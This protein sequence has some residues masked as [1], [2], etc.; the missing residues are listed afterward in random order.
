M[1]GALNAIWVLPDFPA[2]TKWLTTEEKEIAVERIR[3]D[4]VGLAPSAPGFK[5][6]WIGLKQVVKDKKIWLFGILQLAHM[7]ACGFTNFFPSIMKSIGSTSFQSLVLTSPPYVLATLVCLAVAYTSGR[8]NERTWHITV[9]FG[10]ALIGFVTLAI[11]PNPAGRYVS[12]FLVASGAYAINSII[13][14]WVVGTLGQTTEKKAMA[15]G[16]INIFGNS[17]YLFTPFLYS[18]DDAPLY[19]KAMAASA[20][21]A[22]TTIACCWWMRLWLKSDNK[23]MKES[24]EEVKVFYAY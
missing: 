3:R 1:V 22:A 17:S 12:T 11:T 24:E 5:G 18:N 14:G 23:K 6:V 19:P 4:T 20:A 21:F 2:E 8:Y 7:G 10:A 16:M 9:C 15:L 13:L